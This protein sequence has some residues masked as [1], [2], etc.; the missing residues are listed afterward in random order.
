MVE[1]VQDEEYEGPSESAI[2]EAKKSLQKMDENKINL[3]FK[4]KRAHSFNL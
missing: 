3:T 2:F 1:L 4:V